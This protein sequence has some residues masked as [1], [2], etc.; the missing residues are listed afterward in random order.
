MG[1][2]KLYSIVFAFLITGFLCLSPIFY[3]NKITITTKPLFVDLNLCQS[4]LNTL[5]GKH[6]LHLFIFNLID[7]T[8]HDFP[9]IKSYTIRFTSFNR[10]LISLNERQPWISSIIDGNSIFIDK[11]G[12]ILSYKHSLSSYPIKNNIFIIKGLL[13]NDVPQTIISPYMLTQLKDYT[14]LFKRYFPQHNL[15]LERVH[16]RFWQLIL[17]DSIVIFLGDL[18]NLANKFERIN[19]FLNHLPSNDY[20]NL[21]YIDSRIDNKLLVTYEKKRQ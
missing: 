5:L 13:N 8:L 6:L 16:N 4:S 7:K 17:D 21:D 15:F 18:S 14:A 2:I 19:Y 11:D 20:K 10:I 1:K 12:Y 3:L 9:E